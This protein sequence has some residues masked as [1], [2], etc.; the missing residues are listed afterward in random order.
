LLASELPDLA[1]TYILDDDVPEFLIFS[2]RCVIPIVFTPY[3]KR[4]FDSIYKAVFRN[5][6]CYRNAKNFFH[7]EH[8]MGA[9]TRA[10]AP[11]LSALMAAIIASSIEIAEYSLMVTVLPAIFLLVSIILSST[12]RAAIIAIKSPLSGFVISLIVFTI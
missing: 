3:F 1:L 6:S 8:T 12:E 4:T 2:F 10:F 9:Q 7:V 11:S 5:D